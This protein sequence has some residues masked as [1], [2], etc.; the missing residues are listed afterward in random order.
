[1][2]I[3]TVALN[4]N[5]YSSAL[6]FWSSPKNIL[7]LSLLS[8]F[9]PSFRDTLC[10]LQKSINQKEM[11]VFYIF[12]VTEHPHYMIG[13]FRP[14]CLQWLWNWIDLLRPR[15]PP[16]LSNALYCTVY[17]ARG[18]EA[19]PWDRNALRCIKSTN[20]AAASISA[21][22][23]VF[24]WPTSITM[25]FNFWR[26]MTVCGHYRS[27]SWCQIHIILP[28]TTPNSKFQ[29]LWQ[30]SSFWHLKYVVKKYFH[31]KMTHQHDWVILY[32]I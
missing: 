7:T 23:I 4:F 19:P 21:E 5:F 12:H 22:M 11:V 24:D 1:M 26:Y 18:H 14:N 10:I 25:L 17:I 9:I 29:F 2:L 8:K 30:I 13:L 3:H 31:L 32:A 16:H 28:T 15:N 27:V 6:P 20:S